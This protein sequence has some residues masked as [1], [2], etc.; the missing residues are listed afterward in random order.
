VENV[1][2]GGAG[3]VARLARVGLV[4]WGTGQVLRRVKVSVVCNDPPLLIAM[5]ANRPT[6][7]LLPHSSC[8]VPRAS[9]PR[10]QLRNRAVRTMLQR[11][12]MAHYRAL[13]KSKTTYIN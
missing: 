2:R 3:R 6:I 1:V 4:G 12:R 9:C 7:A 8:L 11:A 13:G 10:Y 5:V